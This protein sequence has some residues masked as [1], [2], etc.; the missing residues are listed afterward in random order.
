M[1]TYYL[2]YDILLIMKRITNKDLKDSFKRITGKNYDAMVIEQGFKN[3]SDIVEC[4]ECGSL[5][6]THTEIR[7]ESFSHNEIVSE[8]VG[9]GKTWTN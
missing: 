4:D 3:L 1:L 6:T 5:V 9:C 2:T 8:C 7:T